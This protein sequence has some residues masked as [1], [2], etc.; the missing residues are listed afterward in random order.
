MR[1]ILGL[2]LLCLPASAAE[3]E[4]L[5][6][7]ACTIDVTPRKFPV[8][9]NG[10]FTDRQAAKAN[11]PLNARCIVLSQGSTSIAL[12]TVDSCM[13]PRDLI[14]RAKALA[15]KAT[16]IPP[17]HILV[18]ATHT[19]TAPTAAAVFQSKPDAGY[20]EFL[21]NAIAEGIATAFGKR[22][23]AEIGWMK[24]DVPEH[25]FNRRW[26]MKPGTVNA[27]PFGG[28]SD[29]VRMNP[30]AQNPNLLEPAGPIDPELSVLAIRSVEGMPIALHANYSL[31]YVGDLPMLSADYFGVFCEVVGAKI[32]AK[33]PFT[34][35]LSNGTSG[36]VNNVNFRNAATKA[37]P[38][39]RSRKVAESLAEAVGKGYPRIVFSRNAHLDARTR[40]IE[41]G[42]RKPTEPEV[43]RAKEI[44]ANSAGT[45]LAKP[46]QVYAHE[47]LAMADYP[48]KA[49]VPLQVLRIG[50]LAVHAIPCE[51]FTE[52]GLEL[53]K[54]TP[55]KHAFTVSL[56]NAYQGYLPTPAQHKLGGYETWRAKSSYLEADASG[57]IVQ[58]LM[59]M[60]ADL[61]AR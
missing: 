25:L 45:P 50:D 21:G 61:H 28:T 33:G 13:L 60:S 42:V 41:L 49:S 47:T 7:G 3:P 17:S 24:A 34:A 22:T 44:L 55:F 32:G 9:V 20:V 59:K 39:E 2:L 18:S 51:V 52:I 26:R 10:G 36:D 54:A 35:A 37:M 58:A 11:D 43:A 53:K 16:G 29:A 5:K 31:H 27:D 38:G 15:S 19:H 46:E 6:A 12:V 56:A 23:P 57:K 48:N 40:E 30:G 4:G 8:S 14:D 1:P